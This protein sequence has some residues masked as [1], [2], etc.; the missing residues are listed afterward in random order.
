M[1]AIRR[2]A[3]S[4]RLT[5]RSRDAFTLV[6]VLVVVAILVILAGVGTVGL[7]RYLDTAKESNARMNAQNIQKAM[8]T[9]YVMHDSNWPPD[10]SYLIGADGQ[11]PLIEGGQGALVGPWGNPFQFSIEQ[12]PNGTGDEIP[13]VW[14]TDKNGKRFAWPK[15]YGDG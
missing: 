5:R 15:Q 9:F 4:P 1:L 12:D 13:V 11:K 7:L 8:K 10:L 3:D 2:I 14:T 6:E